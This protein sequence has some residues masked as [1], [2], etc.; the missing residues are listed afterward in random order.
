MKTLLR[1]TKL[2][3]GMSIVLMGLALY[4]CNQPVNK[5]DSNHL[6]LKQ[7]FDG[8]F[9]MGAA[10]NTMQVNG[11]D[12]KATELIEKHYNSIVAENCMK[13]ESLQPQQ[14]VFNFKDADDFVAYGEKNNMHI[15]GHTLVWHS[16][17]PKWLFV[18]AEGNDVPRDT[19]IARMKNHIQTVV[20][21]YKGR[22]HGWD[23][24]N[25][26]ISDSAGLRNSKFL[27]IIGPDYIEL[28]FKFA[29]EA[30]PEAE[31]YYND[32]AMNKPNKRAEAVKL[33]QNLIDKGIRIDGIGMQG[34]YGLMYDVFDEVEHSI[35][36]YSALGLKVM[37]TELDITVLPNP[38]RQ[39]T[40]EISQNHELKAEYNPYENGLPDSVSIELT[41][42]YTRLFK[43]YLKHSDKISRVTFWGVNDGQSWRNYWPIHGRV[44]YPLP[45]DRNY[46][47]KPMVEQIIK[48][49]AETK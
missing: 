12:P 33:A 18:D 30:D 5:N 38:N 16:Q 25:E 1:K 11:N 23:V 31:L 48:L 32:Y 24:V 21:R 28:A 6:S 2:W 9:Y 20:G 7:A 27:Q 45:F 15:I 42:Y 35:L 46:E 4:A 44:D 3:V 29:N 49:A 19:L 13:S 26:A 40:A 22:V 14:G 39:I 41:N 10:L 36:A 37:V 8:K 17:T 43:I 47:P 34:H